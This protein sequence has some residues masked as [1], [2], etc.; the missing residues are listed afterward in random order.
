[1][2][3]DNKFWIDSEISSLIISRAL[4]LVLVVLRPSI[5]PVVS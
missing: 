1:M 3:F 5:D 2:E 4:V